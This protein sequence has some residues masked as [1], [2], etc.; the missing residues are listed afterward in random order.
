M[1]PTCGGGARVLPCLRRPFEAQ[2]EDSEGSGRGP[3]GPA[4]GH[5]R[6]GLEHAVVDCRVVWATT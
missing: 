4:P 1:A 6:S 2:P 5:L 3:R